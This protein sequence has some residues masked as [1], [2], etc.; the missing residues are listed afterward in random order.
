MKGQDLLSSEIDLGTHTWRILISCS[1]G[2]F[3]KFVDLLEGR[4]PGPVGGSFLW[5]CWLCGDCRMQSRP[6]LDLVY[7]LG[8]KCNVFHPGVMCAPISSIWR[9]NRAFSDCVAMLWNWVF[10]SEI[11]SPRV[12]WLNPDKALRVRKVATQLSNHHQDLHFNFKSYSSFH[13]DLPY[14]FI[15]DYSSSS[16][17]LHHAFMCPWFTS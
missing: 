15:G 11:L 8:D 13:Q 2:C 3:V 16:S 9:V 5:S 12:C 6:Y 4:F 7:L 17:R 14:Y 10:S 1:S